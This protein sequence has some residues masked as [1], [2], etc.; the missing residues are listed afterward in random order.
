ME[1]LWNLIKIRH[2]KRKKGIVQEFSD[3]VLAVARRCSTCTFIKKEIP[4]HVF[5]CDFFK[6]LKNKFFTEHLHLTISS[7]QHVHF[8]AASMKSKN[9]ESNCLRNTLFSILSL[10]IP[11]ECV[12]FSLL[13]FLGQITPTAKSQISTTFPFAFLHHTRYIILRYLV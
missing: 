13:E 7:C 10:Y 11:D 9:I 3:A 8:K 2:N 6:I 1:F 12:E 4:A 5:S